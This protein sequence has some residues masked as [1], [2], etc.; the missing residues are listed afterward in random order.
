[1]PGEESTCRAIGTRR[2]RNPWPPLSVSADS[3]RTWYWK[4]APWDVNGAGALL[5]TEQ[6]LLNPNRNPELERADIEVRLQH[7]L[8]ARQVIWLERGVEGDDTDGHIDAVARFVSA[9]GVVAA[10]EADSTDENHRPLR[11]NRTR[12]NDTRLSGGQRLEVVDIPMPD[13]L[14]W[15]G[16]R[17]PASYVNFYAANDVVL[18]P[19]FGC[20]QDD[21]A[22]EILRE[23]FPGRR[24]VPIDCRHLVI[25]LGAVHCLTQQVPVLR[26]TPATAGAA[27][28][29]ATGE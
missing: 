5:A 15:Q 11:A 4:A 8:G 25:G 1:M 13:P 26:Y 12:L 19:R 10:V 7:L 9:D 27:A 22:A 21:P 28:A 3:F 24:I 23:C 2:S 18:V 14:Y 6:C 17:L 20:R 16:R 29:T